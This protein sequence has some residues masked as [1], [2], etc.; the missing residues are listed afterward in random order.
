M[1]RRPNNLRTMKEVYAPLR[2]VKV[3]PLR[4]AAKD[5]SGERLLAMMKVE[6]GGRE[7]CRFVSLLAYSR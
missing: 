5:I 3:E 1:M 2:N 4:F 7:Y 6:D